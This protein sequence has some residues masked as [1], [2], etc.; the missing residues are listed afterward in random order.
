MNISIIVPVYN[1]EKLIGECIQSLLDQEYPKEN[2]EII[3]VNDGSTDNTK[4][5]VE[6]F[7]V[8]LVDLKENQ[9]RLVAREIGAKCAKYENLFFIDSRCS[10]LPNIL[11][12]LSKLQENAI[13]GN[14][15]MDTR[16]NPKARFFYL[17]RKKYYGRYFDD[18]F[19]PI[20]IDKKNFDNIPKG[21][22]VFFCKKDLFL[23]VQPKEKRKDMSD[24]IWILSNILKKKKK[25]LK[26]PDILI[27]YQEREKLYES[28]QHIY[29]RGKKFSDFY[30]RKRGTYYNKFL[31]LNALLAIFII[32][33]IIY[34]PIFIIG[35]IAVFVIYFIL[36]F[37]FMKENSDYLVLI[38]YQ[39]LFGLVF[40]VGVIVAKKYIY[41]SLIIFSLI[42]GISLFLI[43]S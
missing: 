21:T 28:V 9:G 20:Y 36:P 32:L 34:W 7:P 42:I 30:L 10:A 37:F 22:G 25:I 33:S 27:Q 43:F 11:N 24:D 3:V 31:C 35:I 38:K 26:H 23:S 13:V 14:V 17:L 16:K 29:N 39:G 40:F 6:K 8:R 5:I 4:N 15:S 19:E 2:Y 18:K 41:T 12:I 1:E